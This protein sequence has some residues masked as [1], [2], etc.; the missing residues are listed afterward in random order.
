MTRQHV[1]SH[2]NFTLA[3][4]VWQRCKPLAW[5][6]Q[7]VESIK[8]ASGFFLRVKRQG[9]NQ[10]KTYRW[11]HIV[12]CLAFPDTAQHSLGSTF[13]HF[14]LSCMNW[15]VTPNGRNSWMISS[16]SCR[17]GV[18]KTC[19]LTVC[20]DS[21]KGDSGKNTYACSFPGPDLELHKR[22]CFLSC[23]QWFR[24]GEH[25]L[26]LSLRR[27]RDRR[28]C[29]SDASSLGYCQTVLSLL[30]NIKRNNTFLVCYW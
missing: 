17:R 29:P 6:F 19:T 21:L 2:D 8:A 12:C 9:I 1:Q 4:Y 25:L 30:L 24:V 3:L 15:M 28:G 14:I 11:Y 18:S 27:W 23:L 22:C 16:F 5:G 10:S 13:M 26:G 20:V 7:R